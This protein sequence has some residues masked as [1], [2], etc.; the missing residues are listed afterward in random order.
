MNGS[1][2]EPEALGRGPCTEEVRSQ[3]LLSVEHLLSVDPHLLNSTSPSPS[4]QI[5]YLFSSVSRH[6]ATYECLFS[7][8]LLKPRLVPL[9]VY[10]FIVS[11]VTQQ[12]LKL[13]LKFSD[14]SYMTGSL[15]IA[16]YIHAWTEVLACVYKYR[17]P[18]PPEYDVQ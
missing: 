7:F 15:H 3:H 4:D 13:E 2:C 18:T 9:G 10:P 1:P 17:K 16:L 12:L 5:G 6:L 11:H 8:G 14:I